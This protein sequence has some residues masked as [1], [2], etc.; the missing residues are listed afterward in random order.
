VTAAASRDQVASGPATH[1]PRHA[2][3]TDITLIGRVFR[4]TGRRFWFYAT[5][6]PRRTDR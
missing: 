3:E 5:T 4:P 1:Q 2:I 6:K